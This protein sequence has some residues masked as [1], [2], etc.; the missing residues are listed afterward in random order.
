MSVHHTLLLLKLEGLVELKDDE[1]R[2]A[3]HALKDLQAEHANVL[4]ASA[5]DRQ[6]M[7]SRI[8]DL[9]AHLGRAG[10]TALANSPTQPGPVNQGTAAEMQGT[11]AMAA[12]TKAQADVSNLHALR[13]KLL[14]SQAMLSNELDQQRKAN[15]QVKAA[16][17][18]LQLQLSSM[19]PS[20]QGTSPMT[21]HTPVMHM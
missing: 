20:R 11:E 7:S 3:D 18:Q 8:R 15:T 17:A 13:E 9:E 19:S 4:E 5:M 1:L 14:L 21:P 6:L 2:R 12:L 16:N 10:P